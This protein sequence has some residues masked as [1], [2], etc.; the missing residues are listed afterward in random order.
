M[1]S[2]D[3]G[4]GC[5]G[6]RNFVFFHYHRSQ[7]DWKHTSPC[8]QRTSKSTK[9]NGNDHKLWVIELDEQVYTKSVYVYFI[10]TLELTR[11]DKTQ[12]SSRHSTLSR[13]C[14]ACL[15]SL[16]QL[17][18]SKEE[19]WSVCLHRLTL[20][21]F[22]SNW[23]CVFR[24]RSN[25]GRLENIQSTDSCKKTYNKTSQE[26]FNCT[27]HT[28]LNISI[29]VK[30]WLVTLYQTTLLGNFLTFTTDW[31]FPTLPTTIT[32]TTNIIINTTT[33]M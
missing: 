19:R 8:G 31:C 27:I 20:Y 16:Q 22:H 24:G 30:M 10:I 7:F 23:I 11:Q 1:S 9:Q 28:C 12:A 13:H 4:V 32:P 26:V 15:S 21:W 5:Q 17:R 2:L 18:D 29:T 25:R 3:D 14:L 33:P 6:K